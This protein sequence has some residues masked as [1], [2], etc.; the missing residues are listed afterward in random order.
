M[1]DQGSYVMELRQPAEKKFLQDGHPFVLVTYSL[2]GQNTQRKARL[3]KG[4]LFWISILGYNHVTGKIMR[5]DAGG[6]WSHCVPSQ[7]AESA[8]C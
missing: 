2:L 5:T 8:K 3:R 4:D 1:A 6:N 7:E